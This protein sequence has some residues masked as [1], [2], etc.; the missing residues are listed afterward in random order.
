MDVLLLYKTLLS[1]WLS[2]VGFPMKCGG[3][4]CQSL[5]TLLQMRER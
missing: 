1:D 3:F 2:I 4:I 5:F